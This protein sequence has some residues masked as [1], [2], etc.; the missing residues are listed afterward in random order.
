LASQWIDLSRPDHKRPALL[1]K[2]NPWKII[3][4]SKSRTG[5]YR[6]VRTTVIEFIESVSGPLW[7][8]FIGS[9]AMFIYL[10]M[11][12]I[13]RLPLDNKLNLARVI[14]LWAGLAVFYNGVVFATAGKHAGIEWMAGYLQEII[15]AAENIFAFLMVIET[16]HMPYQLT[17]KALFLVVIAQICFQC[18]IYMGLSN[19]LATQTWLPYAL[20]AWLLYLG[21]AS[22]FQDHSGH[23]DDVNVDD[24]WVVKACSTLC[25]GRFKPKYLGE[26]SLF[27]WQDHKCYATMLVLVTVVLVLVDF[28]LEVDVTLVKIECIS[29]PYI[30]FSSSAV[31]AFS[32]PE[33][34]FVVRMLFE[35][36]SALKYGISFILMMFGLELILESVFTVPA[37]A[38]CGATLLVM[39]FCICISP[40]PEPGPPVLLMHVMSFDWHQF[41]WPV[42]VQKSDSIFMHT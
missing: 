4:Q 34:F 36:Y 10:Q 13:N 27:V 2:S 33:L 18:G 38:G 16:F 15:F 28:T 7:L 1:N 17:T 21:V 37:L 30:A 6:N 31:A 12:I 14:G 29:N 19:W 35:R 23:T 41:G 20:G 40:P 22:L 32:V 5:T 39:V 26:H 9:T 8:L 11:T 24:F 3:T 25:C 42:T